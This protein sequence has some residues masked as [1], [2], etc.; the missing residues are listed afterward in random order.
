[1]TVLA[2]WPG[3]REALLQVAFAVVCVL[4]GMLINRRGAL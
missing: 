1:M 4:I 2:L 3:A